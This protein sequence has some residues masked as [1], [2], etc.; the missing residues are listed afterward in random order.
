[1]KKRFRT[2]CLACLAVLALSAGPLLAQR[3]DIDIGFSSSV[4]ASHYAPVRIELSGFDEP[5]QGRVVLT[6]RIGALD[7]SPD[8][9]TV[10]L[11]EGRIA[12]GLL[13]GTVPI[14]DPLN[15]IDVAVLPSEGEPLIERSINLRLFQRVAPFPVVSGSPIDLGG[16]EIVISPNEIPTDWWGLDAVDSLWMTGGGA[17][18]N[19][20]ESIARWVFAGGSLVVFTGED[21]Y[22]ID[23]PSL[24]EM[25][26]LE[27]PHL[28]TPVGKPSYLDGFPR[29]SIELVLS[30][31]E[32]SHPLLYKATY[33]AGSVAVVARRSADTTPAQLEAV[34]QRV[35]AKSWY[36][37]LRYGS[38]LRGDMRVPRP[39]Y[40]IAPSIVLVLLSCVWALR[41]ANGRREVVGSGRFRVAMAAVAVVVVALSVWSGFYANQ[42][43]QLVELFETHFTIQTHTGYGISLGFLGF[44][45][46]MMTRP[47]SI[48]REQVGVPMY[49]LVK[50]TAATSFASATDSGT[51][52]FTIH[53][54]EV[55]DFELY[56]APRRLL[57][58]R[59]ERAGT[60]AQVSNNLYQR[61]DAVYL[62]SEG[63]VRDIGAV[64]EG[65]SA[66]PVPA[67][68]DWDEVGLALPRPSGE[69]LEAVIREF[70][71]HEGTWL[72][73]FVDRGSQLPG[74]QVPT[75]VR[76][77][78][79]HLVQGEE[80]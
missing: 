1:M 45:S 77:V 71:L 42:T 36:S 59:V 78:T 32:S 24:R 4:V 14:Y 62:L 39:I 79:V 51:F 35:P 64:P 23:S 29:G 72:L 48:A 75:E 33:G 80:T 66:H 40:L 49:S 60:R 31:E 56:G 52:E 15:P 46:P 19:A 54:G 58:L 69:I 65:E 30:T 47:V 2:K 18:S 26:P 22:Q 70:R 3:A 25:F 41:W 10:V 67:G 20:W 37:M 28:E 43:K 17:S 50:T 68:V 6:Q 76:A 34:R 44:A 74:T 53:A 11:A 8:V 21:Y 5:F 7:R 12:N 9:V 63:K 73:A 13:T 16:S 57:S 55:R 27:D 38:E 61:L